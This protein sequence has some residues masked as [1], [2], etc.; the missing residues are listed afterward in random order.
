MTLSRYIKTARPGWNATNVAAHV[1]KPTQ[2][3]YQW[4][5]HHPNLIDCIVKGLPECCRQAD[6]RKDNHKEL[7]I[8]VTA[9]GHSAVTWHNL[10]EGG[11]VLCG[12]EADQKVSEPDWTPCSEKEP[13]I[14]RLYLAYRP[15]A[16]EQERVATLYYDPYHNGWGG[17]FPVTHWKECPKPP[18]DV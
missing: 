14:K 8:T 1:G 11:H 7:H 17:Q 6:H 4:Y 15:D 9:D 13:H 18:E 10:P 5:K 12:G 2:T 16:P 3:L